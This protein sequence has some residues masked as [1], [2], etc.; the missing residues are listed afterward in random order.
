M[1]G[2]FPQYHGPALDQ[3][4]EVTVGLR[5]KSLRLAAVDG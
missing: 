3:A 2:S 5:L 4:F 1:D